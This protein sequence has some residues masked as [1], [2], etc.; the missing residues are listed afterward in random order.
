M[1]PRSPGLNGQTRG[2]GTRRA[3]AI[4]VVGLIGATAIRAEAVIRAAVRPV[5]VI[6]QPPCAGSVPRVRVTWMLL[7]PRCTVST[8]RSP[9]AWLTMRVERSWLV[10]TV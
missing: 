10:S 4:A 7:E 6:D 2:N 9:G 1:A 3:A 5:T 8:T